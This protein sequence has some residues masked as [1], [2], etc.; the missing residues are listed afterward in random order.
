MF[1]IILHKGPT[2]TPAVVYREKKNVDV[3]KYNLFHFFT[4]H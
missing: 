3:Q 4:F 2:V 1:I